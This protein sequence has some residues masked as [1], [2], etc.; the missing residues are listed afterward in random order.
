M[1]VS[2]ERFWGTLLS[3]R[4]RR[5]VERS[6]LAVAI[7]SFIVHLL[8]ILAAEFSLF[9]I[10]SSSP[11]LRSP[12]AAV[13]T[14]FSFILIYEVYLLIYFLPKSI[15]TYIA[16]QYEIITLILI[17]RLF[18]DFANLSLSTDWFKIKYDLN[19]TYDLL[20]SLL[21]FYLIYQFHRRIEPSELRSVRQEKEKERYIRIKRWIA[22]LL[23]PVLF[24]LATY[25]FFAWL[26]AFQ[27]GNGK[28]DLAFQHINN[29]FFEHFFSVLIITDVL[30]LLFSLY[31]TDA[32]HKIM[33]NSGFIISTIL[34]RLSF[35]AGGLLNVL[36]VL[37][38]VVFGLLMLVIHNRFEKT[39]N[40][41]KP[42][43]GIHPEP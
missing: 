33:R 39:V 22:G 14:P 6:I 1:I 31:Y 21:L 36:L 8:L 34:L 27:S 16:K 28:P 24:V 12:I 2:L 29:V 20:A 4:T 19:F 5:R 17:R 38:A 18:K 15:S 13:Y 11:L 23:V 40:L 41:S 3:E 25:S 43:E 10:D 26:W 42:H 32:F 37:A 9:G 7:V 30:L 35:S